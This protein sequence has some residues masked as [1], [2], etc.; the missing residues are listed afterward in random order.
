MWSQFLWVI[1]PYLALGLMIVGALYRLILSPLG[2]GSRSS[3]IL[4]KNR[5]KWGSRLFHWGIIFV[6]GGHVIGL[7]V[8][9]GVFHAFGI[10]DEMYH[11]TADIFGGIAGLVAWVGL[12]LLLVRRLTNARVRINSSI[13]DI[14]VVVLLFIVISIGDI[15]TVGY[16]N[17]VGPYEYRTTV[18]PW[19][20]GVL[21][22]HPD[23]TL[24]LHV[25]LIMQIHIVAA[26]AL[27]AV[28]PFTRLVHIWSIPLRF[29][30]R[31][32]LQYRARSM[33]NKRVN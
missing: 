4:E 33:Y 11:L 16:N 6:F 20:R 5:L 10:P 27:L 29:P 26:L 28:S 7:L 3:E 1:Y 19:I 8:P 22:L 25:P 18:N 24:M 15:L 13:A 30:V 23:K 21:L 2:W 17:I 9:I 31:A 14:V 12:L 32:P